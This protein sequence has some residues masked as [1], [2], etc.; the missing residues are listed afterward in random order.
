MGAVAQAAELSSTHKPVGTRIQGQS[1]P[2]PEAAAPRAPSTVQ[3]AM[4]STAVQVPLERSPRER[5]EAM[6]QLETSQRTT[7]PSPLIP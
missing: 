6:S 3:E 4:A 7:A 5:G 1:K 2:Q